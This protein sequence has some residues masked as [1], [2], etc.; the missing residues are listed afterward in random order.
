MLIGSN[1]CLYDHLHVCELGERLVDRPYELI[2]DLVE[3]RAFG[4]WRGIVIIPTC[5]EHTHTYT[6]E[7]RNQKTKPFSSVHFT[8]YFYVKRLIKKIKAKVGIILNKIA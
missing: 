5:C 8:F 1:G 4:S 2:V 7:S 3:F 6:C